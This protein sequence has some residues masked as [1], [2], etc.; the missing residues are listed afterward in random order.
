[1]KCNDIKL[2][3]SEYIDNMLEEQDNI[4]FQNHLLEC[5][6][7]NMY[8]QNFKMMIESLNEID[9]IDP[10]INFNEQ[11]NKKLVKEQRSIVRGL[12]T[13]KKPLLGIAAM[14]LVAVVSVPML[15]NLGSPKNAQ[16]KSNMELASE[17]S[18]RYG[19]N[20]EESLK[21]TSYNRALPP[22][23]TQDMDLRH[24]EFSV[25][26]DSE[27][28][29]RSNSIPEEMSIE[30]KIIR[31][32]RM[33]IEVETFD[34]IYNS[35]IK[36]IESKNGFIQSSEIF[37]YTLNRNKPEETLKSAQIVIRIPS[38]LFLE[39]FESIKGLGTVTDEQING[40]DITRSYIDMESDK[41]N[42][43]IQEERLREVLKKAD[44]VEDIL[45]IENE[46]SR[47][48]GQIHQLDSNLS[49]YDNLVSLSTIN[50]YIRQVKPD[51]VQLQPMSTGIVSKAKNS[52]IDSLNK[53]IVVGEKIFVGIFSILPIAIVLA[54][55]GIPLW[56]FIKKRKNGS[57]M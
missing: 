45:R 18:G 26:S 44:K 32:G 23:T 31:N 46:L 55:L 1:M 13:Y 41:Y 35:I 25:L 21:I 29:M 20:G 54:L 5:D 56:S 8:F 7:C 49:N 11:L 2:R 24:N 38:Q 28:S 30:R 10:P 6:E 19:T 48:R 14:L 9:L 16:N 4:E 33:S 17:D 15:G 53:M 22:N 51:Q 57:N 37:N 52:F 42:L 39:T 3:I 43:K 47:I 36:D 40:Q 12:V 27:E 50:L 34:D